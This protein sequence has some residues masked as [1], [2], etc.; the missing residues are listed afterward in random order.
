MDGW[1]VFEISEEKQ[2]FINVDS[3]QE[4]QNNGVGGIENLEDVKQNTA[5]EDD[6]DF[7]EA[8]EATKKAAPKAGT[9]W[10]NDLDVD[11]SDE[12]IQAP[13]KG[14]SNQGKSNAGAGISVFIPKENQIAQAVK[15]NSNIPAEFVAVGLF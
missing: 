2:A 5:I 8:E 10:G 14:P 4:A 15:K 12:E 13:V 9:K 6:E 11:F 1:P 7:D 3:D